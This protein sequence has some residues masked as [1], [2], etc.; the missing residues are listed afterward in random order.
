LKTTQPSQFK[1]TKSSLKWKWAKGQATALADFGDP[2]HVDGYSL[3]LYDVEDPENP[4]TLLHATVSPGTGWRAKGQKGFAY[5]DKLGVADGVTTVDLQAGADGKA[6]IEVSAK[7]PHLAFPV[8][9]LGLPAIPPLAVQL[10][11]HGECWGAG[12]V[13]A[14][15]KRNTATRFV[16]NSSPSGAFLDASDRPF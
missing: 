14:G 10:R 16:A 1:V 2:V 3:C 5:K 6:R 4:D 15:V 12:Y 13:Q 8:E 9:L 11:G 7:G